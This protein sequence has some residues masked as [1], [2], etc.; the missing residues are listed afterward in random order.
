MIQLRKNL[1]GSPKHC[2]FGNIFEICLY[3]PIFIMIQ[4]CAVTVI[5]LGETEPKWG[6]CIYVKETIY[7]S[8]MLILNVFG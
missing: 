8:E 5:H 1:H 7:A 2:D 4:K 6:V 3:P